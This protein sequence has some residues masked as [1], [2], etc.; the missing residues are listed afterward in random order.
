MKLSVATFAWYGDSTLNLDFPEEWKVDEHRMIGHDAPPLTDEVIRSRLANPIGSDALKELAKNRK[1]CAII[2]DDL[3]RPTKASQIIPHILHELHEAGL[4]N[5][6]IRFIMALGAHHW[7]R[8]DDIYKKLGAEIP[9]RYNVYNHNVYENNVFVGNTSRGTPVYVNREVMKCDL[10]IGVGGIMPHRGFGFGGGA[11]IL[12][13]GVASIDSITH[14]HGLPGVVGRVETNT[15]RLDAEEAA[16][17][18]GLN[19]IVNALVNPNR[20]CCELVCGDPVKAHRAGVKLAREHYLTTTSKA[21]IVVVNGYPLESE[22][23]KVFDIIKRSAN[24]SGDAV[25]LLHTPEG[26]R[27]HYYNG[28][29]GGD[30]GGRNWASGGYVPKSGGTKNIH[31]VS[32]FIS[33]AENQYFGSSSLWV[34][35]W[36]DVLVRLKQKYQGSEAKVAVYPYA[37]IQISQ[38]EASS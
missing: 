33:I 17:M 25:V 28:R 12:L 26:A 10:K 14:N 37:T 15:R 34:K 32:P 11:K 36:N 21:D 27:G 16:Q 29:F 1:E 22:A 13:P 19:F 5:Q 18:A 35:S 3:T 2:V 23:Y 30:Y 8:L 31:V 38:E 7:M 9:N 24:D 6:H 4:E 20:D